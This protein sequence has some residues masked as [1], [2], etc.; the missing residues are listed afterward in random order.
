MLNDEKKQEI[1]RSKIL[2]KAILRRE[3]GMLDALVVFAASTRYE[4]YWTFRLRSMR[5][6]RRAWKLI[7]CQMRPVANVCA[8]PDFREYADNRALLSHAEVVS[9]RMP[10]GK[11]L[12]ALMTI[13]D[14]AFDQMISG[15]QREVQPCEVR[16]QNENFRRHLRGSALPAFSGW[17]AR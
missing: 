12:N 8:C 6:P 10:H 4:F 15:P 9:M 2:A 7:G 13:G 5:S 16:K 11:R 14:H 3:N 1:M 17:R